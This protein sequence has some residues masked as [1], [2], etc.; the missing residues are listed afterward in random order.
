MLRRRR[1]VAA[2][3]ITAASLAPLLML[4]SVATAP[5]ALGADGLQFRTASRY[6]LVPERGVVRV[7]IDVTLGNLQ[8]D[9]VRGTIRTRYYYDRISFAAQDESSHLVATGGGRR[10]TATKSEQKGYDLVTVRLASNLYYRQTQTVRITYD[11]P[12]S[13]PRSD[14][15]IRVG[16]AFA[17]FYAW[18]SGDGGTVRIEIPDG[19]DVDTYGDDVRTTRSGGRTI[20]TATVNATDRWYVGVYA[21]NPKNLAARELDL[22]NRES[23]VVRSWPEDK[24]WADHVSGLLTT[25]LPALEDLL[26]LPWPVLGDLEVSEVHTPTLEGY[27]GIYD[28]TDDEI[29]ITEDLD[30]LVIVHEASHAWFNT[31]LF[32]ERWANEGLADLY[33]SLALEDAGQGREH[34]PDVSRKAKAAFPLLDWGPPGRIDDEATDAREDYGYDASWQLLER[35]HDEIGDDGMRAVIRAAEAETIP[36]IGVGEP[37]RLPGDADWHRFLDLLEEVGGS[38]T[39]TDLFTTW[40]V[41]PTEQSDLQAR[42]SVRQAYASLVDEG[43]GWLPPI[44]VRSPM[45]KWDWATARVGMADA[46][47]VIALRDQLASEASAAGLTPPTGVEALYEHATQSFDG[48]TAL[49]DAQL[50]ALHALVAASGVLAAPRDQLTQWGLDS[51]TQPE[52]QLSAA[53]AA[54]S[55]GDL[56]AATSGA[57]AA[58]ATLAAAPEA[59]RTKALTI[60]GAGAAGVLLLVGGTVVVLVRRRR[61]PAPSVVAPIALALGDGPTEPVPQVPPEA[62]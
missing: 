37:E 8:P 5:V 41:E 55:A 15:D 51:V 31:R 1:R 58:Q 36:Y 19:F 25:A 46:Q 17:S 29:V 45:A 33:A 38:K 56:E 48:A 54:W 50:D 44:L 6:V 61:R 27:A 18:S 28:V 43:N 59:G 16:R 21:D 40:V 32:D 26:G 34:A 11:L 10:L 57:A 14:S 47:E 12:G 39:A 30:D 24:A 22:P 3:V 62:P 52:A 42:A 35:L 20:L 53:E 13:K 49:G 9:T 4:A 7:T 2:I 23:I 60:G